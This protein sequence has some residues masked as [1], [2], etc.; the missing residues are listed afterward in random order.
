MA[1]EIS[2]SEQMIDII[3]PEQEVEIMF[4]GRVLWVNVDGVCRLRCTRIKPE[5]MIWNIDDGKSAA[6]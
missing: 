1:E 4:S 2:V 6:E 5:Q 3:G